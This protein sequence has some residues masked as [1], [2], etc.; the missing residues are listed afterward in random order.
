MA[1][2]GI[3]H[4]EPL[5]PTVVSTD[6]SDSDA[7]TVADAGATPGVAKTDS[8]TFFFTDKD[9]RA[10]PDH[11]QAVD[12]GIAST[13]TLSLAEGTPSVAFS[14]SDTLTLTQTG[15]VAQSGDVPDVA[16]TF[17]ISETNLIA[18]AVADSDTFTSDETP[19]E[20][21]IPTVL[22]L[23]DIDT[24][25]LTEVASTGS[26][27]VGRSIYGVSIAFGHS[28]ADLNPVWTRLDDPAGVR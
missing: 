19:P 23:A 14:S 25:T 17:L 22:A 12:V 18:V 11:S 7:F 4:I 10:R 3:R 28:P 24:L 21:T 8:D 13:D 1:A 27:G 20:I 2:P 16:D 26:G 5:L 15:D 6:K 9:K